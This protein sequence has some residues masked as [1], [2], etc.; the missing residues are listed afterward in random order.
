LIAE[1]EKAR[2][3]RDWA[4]AD[5]IRASLKEKGIILEDSAQGTSW[6]KI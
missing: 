1:R 2:S 5:Q 6:R 3:L 4:K